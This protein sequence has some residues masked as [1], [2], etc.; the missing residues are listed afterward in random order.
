MP[1]MTDPQSLE[2]GGLQGYAQ[3]VIQVAEM[4][5]ADALMF[6]AEN[7]SVK[8]KLK[9][10]EIKDFETGRLLPS[11]DPDRQEM[12]TLVYFTKE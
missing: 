12:L 10:E 8:R 6:I 2:E 9:D 4:Q 1:I 5:K 7:W 11:L 3:A